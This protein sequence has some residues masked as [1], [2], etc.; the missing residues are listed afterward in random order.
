MQFCW[1]NLLILEFWKCWLKVCHH[2]EHVLTPRDMIFTKNCIFKNVNFIARICTFWIFKMLTKIPFSVLKICSSP[3]SFPRPFFK[4]V[5]NKSPVKTNKFKNAILLRESAH[6]WILKMLIEGL[7][8]LRI[9]INTTRHD[10]HK[11]LNLQK[12]QFHCKNL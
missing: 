8:S 3:C 12:Y 5:T 1:R 6:S 2:R 7:S 10:F 11:K 9:C 4:K